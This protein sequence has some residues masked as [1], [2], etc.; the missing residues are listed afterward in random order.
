MEIRQRHSNRDMGDHGFISIVPEVETKV[1]SPN[2]S[3]ALRVANPTSDL[4][5]KLVSRRWLPSSWKSVIEEM[6]ESQS[7]LVLWMLLALLQSK[8][9][10]IWCCGD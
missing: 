2:S 10:L 1:A 3:L 9:G 6:V 5:E 8:A 4:V 7:N